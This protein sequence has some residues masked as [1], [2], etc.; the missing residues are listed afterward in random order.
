MRLLDGKRD[1]PIGMFL[2]PYKSI[3]NDNGVLIGFKPDYVIM[4]SDEEIYVENSVIGIC[5]ESLSNNKIYSGIFGLEILK[6]GVLEL[7]I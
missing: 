6:E 1:V 4:K 5:N 3:G 2:I 7:W